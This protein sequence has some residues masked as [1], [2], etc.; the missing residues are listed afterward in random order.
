MKNTFLTIAAVLLMLSSALTSCK[1]DEL[2]LAT[3]NDITDVSSILFRYV[4][5]DKAGATT[6][7]GITKTID[8]NTKTITVKV[9]PT[10]QVIASIYRKVR[11]ELTLKNLALSVSLSSGAKAYPMGDAPEL[12]INGD[13]SKV[14]KYKVKA[15]NGDEA[16]WTIK[17]DELSMP[18]LDENDYNGTY[19]V[20]GYL[21]HPTA[22]RAISRVETLVKSGPYS[23]ITNLADLGGSNYKMELTVD[24]K[25]NKVTVTA[26]P[27]AAGAPYTMLSDGLPASDPGYTPKWDGS[28]KCNNT[29]DP[30]TET[31]YIRCGYKAGTVWR[32]VEE[33]LTLQ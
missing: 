29:Y 2:N 10:G 23:V 19:N 7:D 21:Y 30:A 12:G 6:L 22:S 31:F 24:P 18:T 4:A 28:S 1:E 5:K 33:I 17:I 25:T 8:K 11:P 27:G 32:V 3:G 9:A 20:R 16:I 26:A 13:W 15:L 14:N